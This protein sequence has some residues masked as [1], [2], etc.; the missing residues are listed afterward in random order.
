M[1]LILL[2]PPG[3]G[4]GTQAQ[5]LVAKH[6]LVQL[7]TGDM[8]R[9]AAAAGT[10][11][12]LRAKEIMARGE[13]VPDD[14]VVDIVSA[15]IDEPDARNGFILDGFPRTVPQ[16]HALDLILRE[17]GFRLDAVIELKVD[18]GSLLQRIEKRIAETKAKGGTLRPDDDPEV[19]RRRLMAYRDQTA[20]L[21]AYYRLQ[22]ALRQVDGMAPIP[23]V[24][25]DIDAVLRDARR[26]GDSS[27][28]NH[29]KRRLRARKAK[30]A[31]RKRPAVPRS[32]RKAKANVKRHKPIRKSIR[33]RKPVQGKTKGRRG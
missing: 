17:K 1:R 29:P 21:V 28:D 24:A 2:G 7:S 32:G 13:L 33:K 22:S 9:A 30:T 31:T 11:I 20:P 14:L 6:G 27:A 19:L 8:L 23:A 3:A 10:P 15:R 26:A 12:G 25:Q 5:R 16:A 18:E 4:K